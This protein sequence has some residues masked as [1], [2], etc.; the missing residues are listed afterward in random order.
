M[1]K[2]EEL[3][4]LEQIEKLIA[5]AGEDSYIWRT[6]SGVVEICRRNIEDD[7]WI[8]PVAE[9]DAER[10][11]SLKKDSEHAEM[12][13]KLEHE[14]NVLAE[15]LKTAESNLADYKGICQ[16]QSEKISDLNEGLEAMADSVDGLQEIVDK[17]ESEIVRLKAEIYD[18]RK[19]CGK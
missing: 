7:F 6:F 11:R 9:L 19:E 17:Q 1:L 12:L 2:Q 3:K 8:S 14:N 15:K 18:L 16:H 5:H 10:E 13:R 4:V